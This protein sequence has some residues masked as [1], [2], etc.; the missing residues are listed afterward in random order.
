MLTTDDL[1]L[2]VCVLASALQSTAFAETQADAVGKLLLID[3]G[4]INGADG[5]GD[6]VSA[7]ARCSLNQSEC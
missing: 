4:K 7:S 3:V 2:L 5:V 1:L 6:V